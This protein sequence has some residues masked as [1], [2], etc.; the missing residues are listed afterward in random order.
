MEKVL[1]A[2]TVAGAGRGALVTS[3][4]GA[5]WIGWGLSAAHAYNPIVG[6]IFG[7]IAIALWIGSL[8]TVRASHFLRRAFPELSAS[9]FRFPWL[10]FAGIVFIEA[11][12]IGAVLVAA[13]RTHRSDI[14]TVGCALVI[15]LHFLPLARLFHAP[16]LAVLGVLI[17]LW[18]IVGWALFRFD[19]LII[20]ISLG[21][22]ILLWAAAVAT[23]WR[24]RATERALRA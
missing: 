18:C 14:G 16:I 12:A 21:T 7:T 8:Y 10:S 9:A 4:A 11:L 1:Q 17:T 5:G 23:L 6:S 22:G 19:A 3:L 20:A 2:H 13:G 15:G 24:A